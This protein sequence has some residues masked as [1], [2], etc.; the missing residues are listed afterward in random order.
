MSNIIQFSMGR[1]S[2]KRTAE[3]EASAGAIIASAHQMPTGQF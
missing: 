1:L 2:A 3:I